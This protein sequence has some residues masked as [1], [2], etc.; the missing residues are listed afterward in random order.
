[1]SPSPFLGNNDEVFQL[2][3][4]SLW[5]VKYEYEYLYEYFPAVVVCPAQ[6][7]LIIKGQDLNVELLSGGASGSAGQPTRG[8]VESSIDGE[9]EGFDHDAIFVLQNGQIWQQVSASYH[10][11]YKYG[12]KVRIYPIAGG[13]EMS[14]EGVNNVVRVRRLN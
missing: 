2:D 12:P 13:Y 6:G 4:G 14:V 11:T 7:K 5:R 10:Y 1:M 8:I 9:F 3:D